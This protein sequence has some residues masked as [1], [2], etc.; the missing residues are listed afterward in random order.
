MPT[1][2]KLFKCSRVE[3]HFNTARLGVLVQLVCVCVC[4]VYECVSVS[5]FQ[6]GYICIAHS[7]VGDTALGVTGCGRHAALREMQCNYTTLPMQ[8]RDVCEHD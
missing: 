2:L 8:E 1:P 4:G 3:R 7:M 5:V 6:E